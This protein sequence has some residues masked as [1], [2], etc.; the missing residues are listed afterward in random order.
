MEYKS[1]KNYFLRDILKDIAKSKSNEFLV[2][3]HDV[4]FESTGGDT[5]F[6]FCKNFRDL[7]KE[8]IKAIKSSNNQVEIVDGYENDVYYF[9]NLMSSDHPDKIFFTIEIYNI[10][11]KESQNLYEDMK[12]YLNID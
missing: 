9:G 2:V 7:K 4:Y 11:E 3:Y 10:T 1:D 8:L 5:H 6:R 12:K